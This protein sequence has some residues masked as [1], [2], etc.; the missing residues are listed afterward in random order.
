MVPDC[1]P[2]QCPRDL[3]ESSLPAIRYDNTHRR[4]RQSW[5]GRMPEECW[6]P[7][8]TYLEH[9]I[10]GTRFEIVPL[11]FNEVS[12]R[13][14]SGRVQFII[15]NPAQYSVLEFFGRAYRIAGIL[16]PSVS[17]PQT[18]FGGVIFT[19]SDRQDIRS[20]ADLKGKRFAA[21]NTESLG[22]WLCARR[23]R[24]PRISTLTGISRSLIFGTHD[25]VIKSVLS[26]AS[27]WKPYGAV[28]LKR[29]LRRE[30]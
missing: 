25:A 16:I 30:R 24:R 28:N 12:E 14:A 11:G 13:V 21:V 3:P 2:A 15:T 20:I 17:G 27:E 26:G 10:P 23:E 18:K 9:H 1:F 5:H 22:G 6:R 29:W 8:A 4:S 19:R 7:T